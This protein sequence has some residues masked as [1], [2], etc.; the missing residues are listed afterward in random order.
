M[1]IVVK[2]ALGA[3]AYLLD[4]YGGDDRMDVYRSNGSASV[5]RTYGGASGPTTSFVDNDWNLVD[6]CFNGGPSSSYL[7][8]N[9][10]TPP[11]TGNAGSPTAGGITL[12]ASGG[13]HVNKATADVVGLFAWNV[14]LPETDRQRIVWWIIRQADRLGITIAHA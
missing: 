11:V 1:F 8:H 14:V 13:T 9:G 4:G 6:C 10:A 7:A 2:S 12:C 3:T 5:I